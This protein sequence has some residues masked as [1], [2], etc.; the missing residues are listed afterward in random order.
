MI[1]VDG[2][3][4]AHMSAAHPLAA[5]RWP[6]LLGKSRSAPCVSLAQNRSTGRDCLLRTWKAM[7]HRPKW[8]VLLLGQWSQNH[9]PINEF[10]ANL[11]AVI[12]RM[13]LAQISVCLMTPPVS[14]GYLP[15]Y[16]DVIRQCAL[17]YRT[18][19]M[20]LWS[21]LQR[22]DVTG[23]WWENDS[24]VKCHFSAIGAQKVIE[25]FDLPENVHLCRP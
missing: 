11:R 9:E 12:E 24:T 21:H 14:V 22:S 25:F 13:H 2:D 10:E 18:G 5:Y 7:Q 17:I 15:P 3:S 4:V 23:E 8:Y 1:V 6:H 19:L 20:D 16:L